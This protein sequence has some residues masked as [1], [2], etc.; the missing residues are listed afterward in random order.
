MS[1]ALQCRDV[2]A[3]AAEEP[4]AKR[5]RQDSAVAVDAAVLHQLSKLQSGLNAR[6]DAA[7]RENRSPDDWGLA[8]TL[9][10]AELID[11]YP[12][13]WWKNVKGQ[14]DVNNVRIELVDILHFSLSGQMQVGGDGGIAEGVQLFAP[15][16]ETPNAIKTFRKVISLT[17]TH[18]F[19]TITR[20]VV[21]AAADLD[22]NIVSYYVAKHTLNYIRQLQGYKNGTYKKVNSGVE[23]NEL[24]HQCIEGIT[25]ADAMQDF[26]KVASGIMVKVYDVFQV[27]PEHRR[28]L[29]DWMQAA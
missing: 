20:L 13:K 24:L 29:K 1:A 16:I 15:L 14:V 23:D 17:E 11:S 5:Q 2:N 8:I 18:S 22:F 10:A 21:E 3:Q 26:E 7:W 6:I 28:E 19:A 12:W 9:E 25:V 4:A 27:A